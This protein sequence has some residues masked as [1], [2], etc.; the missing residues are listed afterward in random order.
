MLL[1]NFGFDSLWSAAA[2]SLRE[3]KTRDVWELDRSNYSNGNRMWSLRTPKSSFENIDLKKPNNFKNSVSADTI[4]TSCNI[5]RAWHQVALDREELKPLS[6]ADRE[7]R[8]ASAVLNWSRLIHESFQKEE[9]AFF[10]QTPHFADE[11]ALWAVLNAK[12]IRCFAL[13]RTGLND[14]IFFDELHSSDQ[15]YQVSSPGRLRKKTSTQEGK[16]VSQ[17]SKRHHPIP[18]DDFW[19]AFLEGRLKISREHSSGGVALSLLKRVVRAGLYLVEGAAKYLNISK[20]RLLALTA[21]SL[22]RQVLLTRW[23]TANGQEGWKASG[24]AVYFA[25]HRQPEATTVPEAGRFWYQ[26]HAIM[27]LSAAVP[28]GWEIVVKEHP[29]QIGM[30]Y[31]PDPRVKSFRSVSDY[32]LINSLHNVTFLA[33]GTDSSSVMDQCLIVATINGTSGWEALKKGIPTIVFS[34]AWY[35]TSVAVRVVD[36][37]GAARDA[38]RDLGKLDRETVKHSL[39]GLVNDLREWGIESPIGWDGDWA[40]VEKD[41]KHVLDLARQMVE[42]Q[43]LAEQ[44]Q[45]VSQ[46]PI[47]VKP[48]WDGK[49]ERGAAES[50]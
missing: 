36:S 45:R 11:I 28:D 9:I 47:G 42:L 16:E 33:P 18:S 31:R 27:L 13:R 25:L 23:L 46:D 34:A 37:L 50:H 49:A 7:G 22:R 35:S 38:I 17:A 10:S 5:A 24:P 15:P 32:E 8:L 30:S 44:G 40:P 43:R 48:T 12:G 4:L 21:G 20:P 1:V 41:S 2:S 26:F 19:T 14:L 6:M 3:I 39:S 29:V